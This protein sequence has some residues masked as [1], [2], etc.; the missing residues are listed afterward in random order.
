MVHVV[1]IV[2]EE[3]QAKN[4]RGLDDDGAPA[5]RLVRLMLG[6]GPQ[7]EDRQA[8]I[9]AEHIEPDGNAAEVDRPGE[10]DRDDP[11]DMVEPGAR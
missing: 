7:V 3:E 5:R 1:E 8:E 4:R 10:H 2:V 6:E 9:G 11:S